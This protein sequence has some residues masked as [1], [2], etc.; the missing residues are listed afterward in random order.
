MSLSRSPIVL[1]HAALCLVPA[2]G[3]AQTTGWVPW[4]KPVKASAPHQTTP[5]P[6]PTAAGAWQPPGTAQ[7]RMAPSASGGDHFPAP[8]PQPAPK[9]F[10]KDPL[11]KISA[12][13][14]GLFRK[15]KQAQAA[16]VDTST[17]TRL[18][19]F[20]RLQE[21]RGQADQAKKMYTSLV[22]RNPNNPAPYHRLGV[23]AAEEGRYAEAEEFLRQA[24][25]LGPPSAE[26]LTDLGYLYYLQHRLPEAETTLREAIRLDATHGPAHVNLGLVA[27]AQGRYEESLA[28]FRRGTG[29][30]AEAQANLAYVMAQRGDLEQSE[31][32]Y[33]RALTLDNELREAAEAMLQV[34]QRRQARED[35]VAQSNTSQAPQGSHAQGPPP[36]QASHPAAEV[37]THAGYPLTNTPHES[38]PKHTATPKRSVEPAP[39]HPVYPHTG[40]PHHMPQPHIRAAPARPT[41]PNVRAALP[42]DVTSGAAVGRGGGP[43]ASG[44][45]CGAGSLKQPAS[46]TDLKVAR[47]GGALETEAP[48]APVPES[49]VASAPRDLSPASYEV[50]ATDQ[51]PTRLR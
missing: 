49:R 5:L 40:V 38:P 39:H 21:R 13:V 33:L 45:P 15:E 8:D 35:R 3:C 17:E 27:G 2:V 48:V 29:G 12:P 50:I 32:A 43:S 34:A 11:A 42:R 23:L 36:P 16:A 46:I 9:P 4:A 22:R 31:K 25:Q 1:L 7:A 24:W 20:A 14:Q 28:E 37:S 6:G 47:N 18:L 26:L 30:E 51:K 10:W 19:A 41:R 44:Q